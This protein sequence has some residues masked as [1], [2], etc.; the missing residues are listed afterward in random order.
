VLLSGYGLASKYHQKE[1][2]LKEFYLQRF[3]KIG[4]PFL[5]WTIIF[6]LIRNSFN[7]VSKFF[8]ELIYYLFITGVDYHLYFFIII[9][10]CYVLF[11]FIIKINNKIFLLIL[12]ILQLYN[13]SPTD[14]IISFFGISFYMFPSTFFLRGYFIFIWVYI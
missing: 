14:K 3:S 10:Q 12:F 5:F 8:H 2:N 11:P 4:I 6:V 9:L 13:Y 7:I 1:I